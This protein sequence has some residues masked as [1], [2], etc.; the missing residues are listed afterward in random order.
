MKTPRKSTRSWRKE[1]SK[2][3]NERRCAKNIMGITPRGQT[4]E[5]K[6]GERATLYRR[7]GPS[8]SAERTSRSITDYFS[9][10]VDSYLNIYNNA[11]PMEAV[12]RPHRP[13]Q[14]LQ[15]DNWDSRNL[16]PLLLGRNYPLKFVCTVLSRVKGKFNN[17]QTA[18]Q[19]RA[20][21]PLGLV[22][23][24]FVIAWVSGVIYNRWFL[25][26]QVTIPK[27]NS[28]LCGCVLA[29]TSVLSVIAII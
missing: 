3:Q 12:R 24:P 6:K 2:I 5:N 29:F 10:S 23:I 18:Q 28:A 26:H 21:F 14:A 7:P 11:D 25:D 19:E 16:H 17:I 8:S 27:K 22:F 4:E 13:V 15:P 1:K 20:E 9:T